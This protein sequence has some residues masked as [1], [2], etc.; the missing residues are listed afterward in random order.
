MPRDLETIVLKCLHK[1]PTRRYGSAQE[2]ADDLRRW[3]AGEPIQAR[4]VGSLERTLRWVQRQ[5]VV[6]GLLLALVLSLF[7][8]LGLTGWQWYRAE[9][10]LDTALE[11]QQRAETRRLEAQ[12]AQ[13]LAEAQREER[14]A[15]A[16]PPRSAGRR[17]RS[18]L[19]EPTRP[20]TL[21]LSGSTRSWTTFPACKRNAAGCSEML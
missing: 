5:P 8:G 17:P 7:L 13:T 18:I 2:L 12:D 15:R 10:N 16:R 4:P 20:S 19:S 3:L 21:S 6:A 14:A 1:E 9:R 11:A